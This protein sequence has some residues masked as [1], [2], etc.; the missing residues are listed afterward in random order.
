M[1]EA[2]QGLATQ[3]ARPSIAP[4]AARRDVRRGFLDRAVAGRVAADAARRRTQRAFGRPDAAVALHR[5]SRSE[6]PQGDSC[7]FE[8][9]NAQAAASYN[10]EQR[11]SSTRH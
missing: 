1:N 5:R 11:E 2:S 3:N 9:A 8:T 7:I 4:F 10:G 6:R